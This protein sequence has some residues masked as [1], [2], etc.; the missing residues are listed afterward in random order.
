MANWKNNPGTSVTFETGNIYGFFP[1]TA[2]IASVANT[3]TK[4]SNAAYV[5]KFGSDATGNGSQDRPYGSIQGAINSFSTGATINV[6]IVGN[7]VYREAL[8]NTTTK[9]FIFLADGNVTLEGAGLNDLFVNPGANANMF[10][11]NGFVVRNYSQVGFEFLQAIN[12]ISFRN[13]LF[14]NVLTVFTRGSE[15]KGNI[16][17]NATKMGFSGNDYLNKRLI[18]NNTFVNIKNVLLGNTPVATFS[19]M[20][21]IFRNCNIEFSAATALDYSL[22]YNCNFR[23]NGSAGTLPA[24]LPESSGNTYIPSGW[25][26]PRP[27]TLP[28]LQAAHSTAFSATTN[29]P[30][31]LFGDPAF[32]SIELLDFTLQETSPAR[33]LAYE[34]TFV[35]A[36]SVGKRLLVRATEANGDFTNSGATNLTIADDAATLTTDALANITSK[37]IDLG[38]DRELKAISFLGVLGDRN[39]E[40][41]DTNRDLDAST[42]SSGTSLT[43]NDSYIV[44]AASI[45]ITGGSTLAVGTKFTAVSGQLAFT[46]S[47]VVRKITER[48]NRANY[49][50]KFSSVSSADCAAQSTWTLIEFGTKPTVNRTGN[51]SSGSITKGNGDITFDF[52]NAFSIVGRWVQIKVSIQNNDLA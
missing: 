4:P 34:G 49:E 29:F 9:N 23:F 11:L 1:I 33:N 32:N 27:T 17:V 47:G 39:G 41:P 3:V 38:E 26:S 14:Y 21:N 8:I 37:V 45:T 35:G 19:C 30:N 7:G 48:P 22:F 10:I 50:L 43:A 13:C 24:S 51:T 18:S 6:I 25:V 12:Y 40:W 15:L 31:C 2:T 44:E 36:K 52:A 28:A 16:F 42:I 20:H 46:G 5:A